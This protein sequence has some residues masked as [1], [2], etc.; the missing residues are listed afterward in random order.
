MIACD[1][2]KKTSTMKGGPP[3]CT[4]G[5]K[6]YARSLRSNEVGVAQ[7]MFPC[8]RNFA[9]IAQAERGGH[10]VEDTPQAQGCSHL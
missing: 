7:G 4:Q 6:N 5:K 1:A 9:T 2:H 8:G 3:S 10:A